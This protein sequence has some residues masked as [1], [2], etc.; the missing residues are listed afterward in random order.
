MHLEGLLEP[1]ASTRRKPLIIARSLLRVR[2][3]ALDEIPP[4]DRLGSLESQLQAWQAFP[5]PLVWVQ[6]FDAHAVAYACDADV[7]G[8][9]LAAES[10]I[11]P[12]PALRPDAE[13]GLRL[14]R[15]LS[16]FEGQ[17]WRSGRLLHSRWWVDMPTDGDW[18]LFV[19][20]S[21]QSSGDAALPELEDLAWLQPRR[22]LQRLGQFSDGRAEALKLV[23]GLLAFCL[24][25]FGAYVGREVQLAYASRDSAAHEV[26]LLEQEAAPAQAAQDLAQRR[27][28][29]LQGIVAGLQGVEP[30]ALI[31]HLARQLQRGVVIKELE[32]QGQDLRL[33]LE[34][35]AEVSR[36]ALIEALESGAWLS[37]LAEQ[38]D[39]AGNR[40]WVGLQ[41]HLKQLRPP[42]A[43][44]AAVGVKQ[45][46]VAAPAA[47]SRSSVEI[48]PELLKGKP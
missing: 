19:R 21:A 6:V 48:P 3:I 25:G 24:L 18:Q 35:P 30:L 39:T 23:A 42:A 31:D 14:V 38:K 15:C 17:C 33:L 43:K 12:E 10:D 22:R 37:G 20:A 34:L 4:A 2:G 11:W 41:A 26:Q 13:D 32:L 47:P 44:Q 28:Q 45:G 46:A 5:N 27:R 29:E 36:S 1:T 40:A 16:G 7:L 9:E 8:P